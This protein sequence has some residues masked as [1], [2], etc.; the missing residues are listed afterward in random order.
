M[1]VIF[2]RAFQPAGLHLER[3]AIDGG[4]LAFAVGVSLLTGLL[5]G[6]APA[7]RATR[8]ELTEQL[9][10]GGAKSSSSARS[11][12]LHGL[13]VVV[14]VA[15]AVVLLI[16]AGLLVRSFRALL[17]V[18]PGF[19]PARVY[20]MS[21]VLPEEG[22]ADR[23]RQGVFFREL[24]RR[25]KAL[26]GAEAAALVSTLPLKTFSLEFELTPLGQPP[27]R[28]GEEPTASYDAVS[29]EYFTA[30]RIPLERGRFFT[31]QD[32][33]GAPGV[34]IVSAA[35]ARRLWPGQQAL[36]QRLK[37][38][39]RGP[40]PREVVG[41][42]GDVRRAG[43]D[44][45]PVAQIYVPYLQRPRPF[46]TVVARSAGRPEGLA[47]PMRHAVSETDKDLP[48]SESATLE[49]VVASSLS[50]RR[51]SML[52]LGIF[53]GV[54][55]LLSVVGVYSLLAFTV[56]ERTHEIGIRMALGAGRGQVRRLVLRQ[57]VLLVGWGVAIGLGAALALTRL[58]SGLL[59]QVTAADPL[60]YIGVP[61]VL[62]VAALAASY[63]PSARALRIDPMTA[64]RIE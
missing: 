18:P 60:T 13:L 30:L 52:L 48:V 34:A 64:M 58:V 35:L 7:L 12:R 40:N 2:I 51:F 1:G 3:V 46:T 61:L 22:Y 59:Y 62:V 20:T 37:I 28:P 26:P 36:G 31:D 11:R 53:A 45:Q 55:L 23:A 41:V 63:I 10:E 49:E 16:G 57:G 14:E 54:A 27:P 56:T 32:T 15:L 38:G 25:V 47:L 43:L 21:L 19:D 50:Q 8:A 5:C 24:L 42:V 44:A 17:A 6:L 29:P 39:D 4:V 33:S 9:K